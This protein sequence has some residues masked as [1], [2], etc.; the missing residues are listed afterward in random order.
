MAIRP[1]FFEL[2][3]VTRLIYPGFSSPNVQQTANNIITRL[4]EKSFM[5]YGAV[6]PKL[7]AIFRRQLHEREL[8]TLFSF[9]KDEWKN[10]NLRDVARLLIE[11]FS[12]RGDWYPVRSAPIRV[13][14]GMYLRAGIKGIWFVDG[15]AYAVLVNARKGQALTLDHQRFLARGVYE[16]YC[17]DDP[18]DPLGFFLFFESFAA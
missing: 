15:E 17:I 7:S 16:M 13:V 4:N 14:R 3:D 8:E 18:N 9:Y 5:S 6:W 1:K 11:N 2:L 12:G 10:N